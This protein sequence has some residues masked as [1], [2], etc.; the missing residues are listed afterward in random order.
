MIRDGRITG[1]PPIGYMSIKID[2]EKRDILP[3]PIRAPL[4][5]RAFELYGSGNYSIET[6]RNILIPEGLTN[7]NGNPIAPSIIER[8][9]KN[10]FYHGIIQRKDGKEFPHR[11]KTIIS[12]R[13]FRDCQDVMSGRRKA[14]TKNVGKAYA[15]QGLLVCA[16]CGCSYTPET[17]KGRFVYY[18]CTNARRKCKKEYVNEVDLLTP[19]LKD[20]DLMSKL[21]KEHIER[22]TSELKKN[23]ES[24]TLYHTHA[25][26]ALQKQYNDAQVRIDSLLNLLIDGKI[27]QDVYDK[28]QQELKK[29]QFDLGIQLEDYTKADETLRGILCL[30][31]PKMAGKLQPYRVLCLMQ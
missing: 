8:M 7:L 25:I 6:L 23:H 17:H 31:L 9:L 27:P 1:R 4:I 12:Q 2:E 28:K 20:L 29:R 16:N 19:I 18:S 13:L 11:Y 26:G 22:I 5:R 15:F 3:D 30:H 14:P 24:K 21:R 10:P